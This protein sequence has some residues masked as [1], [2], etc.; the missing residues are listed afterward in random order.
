[1]SNQIV[2]SI[3]INGGIVATAGV[4]T[5]CWYVREDFN[6]FSLN[7]AFAGLETVLDWAMVKDINERLFKSGVINFCSTQS[8]QIV[9]F[10]TPFPSNEYFVFFTPN[11]NVNL[12]W[13]DKK[14]FRFVI[15]GSFTMGE[16]LSWI[17]I[18][19]NMAAMT[20]I[21]NPGSIY[22]GKRVLTTASLP[23]IS[24]KDSLDISQN[25][26]SNLV[27]WYN[28]EMII[29]PNFVQDGITTPMDL[30]DYTVI[31]SSNTNINNYWIEKGTDR[32]KIGTSY[33]IA[34]VIDYMF[35]KTG[36]NWWEEI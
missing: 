1:M 13:V 36:I 14:T 9:K 4:N 8:S 19:K 23:L 5:N 17:A 12:Y 3:K 24:G 10:K 6:K 20:G 35:I 25:T 18:H 28:N 30:E 7:G 2:D 21:S 32:V 26:D 11:N 27:G 22:S 29:Q 31:L 34:C 16:E 33:P 15:N